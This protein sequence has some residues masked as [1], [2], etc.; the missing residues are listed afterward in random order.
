MVAAVVVRQVPNPAVVE[1]AVELLKPHISYLPLPLLLL[2]SDK[3][4]LAENLQ[5]TDRTELQPPLVLY[6]LHLVGT[7]EN[8]NMETTALRAVRLC[9]GV[10]Q[11]V[12]EFILLTVLAAV[13]VAVVGILTFHKQ[14]ACP[15]QHFPV[16]LAAE[17]L[18][19]LCRS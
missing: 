5:T 1:V 18:W 8:A 2:L 19:Y 13:V 17:A 16:V 6:L 10:P 7:V 14:A 12:R 11:E 9:W 3:V 15:V 4:A